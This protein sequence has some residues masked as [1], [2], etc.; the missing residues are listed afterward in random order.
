MLSTLLPSLLFL[1]L[2]MLLTVLESHFAAQADY[3]YIRGLGDAR[4]A[5]VVDRILHYTSYSAALGAG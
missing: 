5:V 3:E 2:S 1:V 4:S